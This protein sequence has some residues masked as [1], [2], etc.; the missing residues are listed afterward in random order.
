LK[1]TIE[2]LSE[3]QAQAAPFVPALD[4]QSVQLARDLCRQQGH[5]PDLMVLDVN[6]AKRGPL[7]STLVHVTVPA[8]TL[9]IEAAQNVKGALS[10]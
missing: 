2:K 7:G 4:W 6:N 5:D 1:E 8:W 3:V 10:G 9:Y